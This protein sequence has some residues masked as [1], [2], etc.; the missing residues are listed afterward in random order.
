MKEIK[1]RRTPAAARLE[2]WPTRKKKT[3]GHRN[4]GD[5]KTSWVIA[6]SSRRKE[7]RRTTNRR[8]MY[9]MGPT[10]CGG[11]YTLFE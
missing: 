11:D 4:R 7:G 2:Y 8:L 10:S 1:K 5:W 3:V 9:D 6:S